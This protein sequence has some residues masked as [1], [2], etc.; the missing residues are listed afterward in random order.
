[1]DGFDTG[2]EDGGCEDGQVATATLRKRGY[3]HDA[4]FLDFCYD[5]GNGGQPILFVRAN[6]QTPCARLSK[7]KLRVILTGVSKPVPAE[8]DPKSYIG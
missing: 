6:P 5:K 3:P 8:V 4:E 2:Y 7:D 1:M